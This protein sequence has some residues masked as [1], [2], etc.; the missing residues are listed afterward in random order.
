MGFQEFV[1][2]MKTMIDRLK[3]LSTDLGLSNTGDEYK[4]IS[5]LFT[6]KFLNDK[7]LYEFNKREDKTEDFDEFVY[8][9]DANTAKMYKQHLISELFNQQSEENFHIIFDTALQEVSELNKDI[10]SIET[11]TG[12]KKP[13]FEPLS[14]Y[15]RDEDK[16]LELAKRA[17]N[18]LQEFDF[19]NI[20]E[21]GF[22]YFSI[23]F[24]YLIADYNKD[25]GKYAEFFTPLFAGQ[26]MADII[27]DDTPVTNVSVYDPAAGSGTLLL[28]LANKIGTNNCTIYS[29][30]ISQKST[31]F[32]R[33]NLI[34]NKLA[35]S[36]HNV[37]EGNTLLNPAHKEGNKL[38]KFDFIVS[39]PPFKTDFSSITESL[40][41]DTY[42]RFFAGVPN[43][44]P[45]K[46]DDMAIYLCFL[47]HIMST[48]SDTGKAAVVVPTGFLT[49][50]TG[51]PKKIREQIIADKMLRGVVSLPS[52]IFA[53]TSTN[54]SVIF[55]DK[56][57]SNDSI[58]LLDAS[59]F[60][61]KIKIDRTNQK[62][63]LSNEEIELIINTF[64]NKTVVDG[65][66]A[67]VTAENIIQ[68]NYLFSAGQYFDV[69]IEHVEIT[70][71]EFNKKLA[72]I[73]GRLKDY[74]AESKTLDE[75]IIK[76][77]GELKY[78]G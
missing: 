39:N 3:I 48:L 2:Q 70:Q 7:L 67:L 10:Y 9:A 53:N 61:T 47:Q 45:K 62:T 68:K 73:E 59:N 51:I 49:A 4:I 78:N 58:I 46:K 50:K 11:T 64:K 8:Y 54:V 5:E 20:Y 12:N 40:K 75:D 15:L 44:P 24:E 71:D 34:L 30:D 66:S 32:L 13:L 56:S 21:G 57:N 65:L 38:Q 26:I 28:S 18:I 74:F 25:S 77:L 31:S 16:E 43:I 63:V 69:K 36:L 37:K 33:I 35:H 55:L 27:F 19:G 52:N 41:A 22:D 6:Y 17:I 1:T 42:H 72:E 29:Q 76:G 14:A 60:G 23:V